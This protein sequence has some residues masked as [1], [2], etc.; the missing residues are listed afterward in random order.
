MM[1]PEPI[2]PFEGVS[3]KRKPPIKRAARFPKFLTRGVEYDIPSVL[4]YLL[5]KSE[6]AYATK[7]RFRRKQY[8]QQQ[9]SNR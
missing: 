3:H 2:I 5:P 4:C 6:C 1:P 8:S 9:I 7:Q